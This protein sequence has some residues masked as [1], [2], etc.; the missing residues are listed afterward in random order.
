[1]DVVDLIVAIV[2][3]TILVTVVVGLATYVA[4]KFRLARQPGRTEPEED[5]HFFFVH[6]PPAEAVGEREVGTA[7]AGEARPADAPSIAEAEIAP[8]PGAGAPRSDDGEKPVP[9]EDARGEPTAGERRLRA[10][11]SA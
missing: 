7:P 4:Y 3:V 10:E 9:E 8:P 11:G 2:V 1:M 5:T 6:D